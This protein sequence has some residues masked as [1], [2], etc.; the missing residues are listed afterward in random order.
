MW[1]PINKREKIKLNRSHNFFRQPKASVVSWLGWENLFIFGEL[2]PR[3]ISAKVTA[4]VCISGS[5]NSS[6]N[7]TANE[8]H[9]QQFNLFIIPSIRRAK[10]F[11]RYK[12][13]KSKLRGK[14]C[15]I[16][17]CVKKSNA[18]L[19]RKVKVKLKKNSA[20]SLQSNGSYSNV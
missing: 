19:G 12:E 2:S 4:I 15:F 9:R 7:W 5:R 1:I 16:L 10:P 17:T 6:N 14:S 20:C 13:E 18:K 11:K 8:S 3:E